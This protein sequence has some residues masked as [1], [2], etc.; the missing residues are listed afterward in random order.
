MQ[1]LRRILQAGPCCPKPEKGTWQKRGAISTSDVVCD[2]GPMIP[3]VHIKPC[4][5]LERPIGPWL[6]PPDRYPSQ[7]GPLLAR[8]PGIPGAPSDPAQT[9]SVACRTPARPEKAGGRSS[10]GPM[11]GPSKP[12]LQSQAFGLVPSSN[13]SGSPPSCV[14]LSAGP[15]PCRSNYAIRVLHNS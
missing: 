1:P 13:A 11:P 7:E 12:L 10:L 15:V 14:P 6:V 8:G 9:F 4:T 5:H 2:A 3:V